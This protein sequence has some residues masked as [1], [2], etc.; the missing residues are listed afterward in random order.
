MIKLYRVFLFTDEKYI[1]GDIFFFPFN[2]E[3]L[4]GGIFI[5][6]SLTF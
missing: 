2:G 1:E 5:Y 4:L 3:D 6:D